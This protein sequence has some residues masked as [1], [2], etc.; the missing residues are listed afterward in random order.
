[1]LY[2][3]GG[4]SDILD[5]YIARRMGLSSPYG[6]KLDSTADFIFIF[7]VVVTLIPV[8]PWE[9]WMLTWVGGIA[10]IRF[11]TFGIGYAKY[12]KMPWLHTIANKVT[13]LLLFLT[14]LFWR[15]GCGRISAYTLYFVAV[16]S[17]IEELLITL[18]RKNLDSNIKSIFTAFR[19]HNPNA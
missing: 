16:V 13:G 10:A 12:H 2:A 4:I 17:A 11:I 9:P 14:P 18:R 1:M 15:L 3:I 8:F 6:A 7:V 19:S 5:G